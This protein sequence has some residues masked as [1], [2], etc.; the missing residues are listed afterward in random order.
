MFETILLIIVII[1]FIV[2][3]AGIVLPGIPSLPVIFL[4]VVIYA[5]FTDFATVGWKAILVIG[6]IALLG[7]LLDF[8]ATLL[9]AKKFGASRWGLLGAVVG[10]IVGIFF[11][12]VGM[13]IGAFIGAIV[14]EYFKDANFKKSLGAGVGTFIGFI[15]GTVMKVVFAI[16]MIILFFFALF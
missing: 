1:I 3:I 4:G 14:L 8:F 9:G 11:G 16:M 13:I 5:F 7:T 2:G 12:P 6:L 15:F 10:S